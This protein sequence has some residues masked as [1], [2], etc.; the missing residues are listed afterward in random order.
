MYNRFKR[1]PTNLAILSQTLKDVANEEGLQKEPPK[2]QQVV[3]ESKQSKPKASTREVSM[4]GNGIIEK[5]MQ[6]KGPE[7]IN[8][9]SLL[10]S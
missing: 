6:K 2:P 5:Q 7:F 3:V 9:K 4:E 10:T 8:F 1:R